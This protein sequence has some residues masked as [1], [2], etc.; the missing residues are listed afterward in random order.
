MDWHLKGAGLRL[1]REWVMDGRF[2]VRRYE[3][4]RQ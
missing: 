1:I 2:Y 3:K 4:V